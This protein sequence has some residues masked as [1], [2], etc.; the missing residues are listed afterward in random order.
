ML[1]KRG[2]VAGAAAVDCSAAVADSSIA[3]VN[4]RGQTMSLTDEQKKE[5]QAKAKEVLALIETLPEAQQDEA[6]IIAKQEFDEAVAA[7]LL[8]DNQ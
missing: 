1:R 4:L 3:D 2:T 8:A 7:A 5:L 6:L